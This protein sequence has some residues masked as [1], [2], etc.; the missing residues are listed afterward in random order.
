MGTSNAKQIPIDIVGSSTFG[1]YPKIS[2]ARTYNMYISD[3]WL[4]NYSGFKKR[5]EVFPLGEG[6]GFFNSIRGN[7]LF[8]VVASSVYRFDA[9][10]VPQFI[11]NIDTSQGEVYIDENLSGQILLVDGQSAYL[12]NYLD[13]SFT[14]QSLFDGLFD[15]VPN[16]VVYHNTFF[17]IAS[18]PTN[19]NPQNW[20]AFE[21]ATT[22]T[23]KL[24]SQF[25]IQTKPDN[26][27]AVVRL[28]GKGNSVLAMGSTVCELWMQIGGLDNY[29]RSQTFNIDSG[30]LSVST[31]ASNGELVVWLSQNENSSPCIR[32]TDGGSTQR[33]SSD[34]IDHL[35]DQIQV[36]TDS[37]AFLF[38]ND[39][40]LFYQLT[41]FNPKDN[42]TLVYDFT[43]Q[44]FYH[45][46]DEKMD[47]H[48]ARKVVFFN[49]KNYFIS[50]NDASIYETNTTFVT[51]DYSLDK[52]SIGEEIP[53]I[54][55]CST[56]RHPDSSTFRIGLLTFWLEQGVNPNY[57]A[58]SDI[59]VCNGL[60][61]TQQGDG[62]ILT[63]MG[64][65]IQ[66]QN[67]MCGTTADIPRVDMSFSKNG[68]Q[69][70]SNVVG[71]QLNHDGQYRNQLRWW[72]LGQCNE[73]T[74]QYRFWG[75]QRFVA[76]NGMAE[77]Y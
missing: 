60:L 40:H 5:S 49:D 8:A 48:P 59:Q 29:R 14:K 47:F 73:F 77:V 3:D 57:L 41:F 7:F 45:L 46:T 31:I 54:R 1:R 39:G 36:P 21:F 12:Y 15:I 28:P 50:L 72:R 17:L 74:P 35:M 6:R 2:T 23:I 53:R 32:T 4:V 37:T 43:T 10:F 58:N 9:N 69:S 67:G 70:F 42:L 27:L 71:R 75:F 76:Y 20:Y 66:A 19:V 22:S 52:T 34:G 16:Y 62:H 63:E 38:R 30:V 13:N 56:I 55:I 11:A 51:Y 26:A 61:I 25:A 33:I 65:V 68:N 64:E 18:A 44:K 24:N